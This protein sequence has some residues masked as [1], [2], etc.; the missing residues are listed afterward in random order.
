[1]MR[2]LDE[3]LGLVGTAVFLMS[4]TATCLIIYQSANRL[5]DDAITGVRSKI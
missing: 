3:S 1:M 5:M 2:L 4:A